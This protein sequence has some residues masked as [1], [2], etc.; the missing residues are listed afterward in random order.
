MN[1]TTTQVYHAAGSAIRASAAHP[2]PLMAL[3]EFER[4]S[5]DPGE[6]VRYI[7]TFAPDRICAL[8]I[9]SLYP[10]HPTHS[11]FTPAILLFSRLA[12]RHLQQQPVLHTS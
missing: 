7:A 4:V 3:V 2:V 8:D 1:Y 12:S 6:E 5:L 11:F 10:S 9:A